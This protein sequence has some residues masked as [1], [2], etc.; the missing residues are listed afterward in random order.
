LG[1]YGKEKI[2]TLTPCCIQRL[3]FR[4]RLL[5]PSAHKHKINEDLKK[6]GQQEVIQATPMQ[7]LLQFKISFLQAWLKAFLFS[8][9]CY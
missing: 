3:G 6:F 4:S 5:V 1:R 2:Y 8:N 9:M 7:K